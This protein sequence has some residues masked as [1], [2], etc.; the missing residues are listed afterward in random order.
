MLFG[1]DANLNNDFLGYMG[2]LL[3]YT[4]TLV[5]SQLTNT[6]SYLFNKWNTIPASPSPSPTPSFSV[7]P[8]V[9]ITPSPTPVV[10]DSI[11]AALSPSYTASYDAA[12]VGSFVLVDS[13]SYLSVSS[14]V[15]ATTYGMNESTMNGPN[16]TGTSWGAPFAFNFYQDGQIP[17]GNYIVAFSTVYNNTGNQSTAVYYG[18]GSTASGSSGTLIGNVMT[19]NVASAP[20][21]GSRQYFVRKAPTDALPANSWTYMWNN[22]GL[23]IKGPI[24]NPVQYKN[25]GSTA[26]NP[27]LAGGSYSNWTT[28]G[29]PAHQFLATTVKSW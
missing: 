12:S 27:T 24:V 25:V 6:E 22:L 28:A 3:V 19:F 26:P 16:G 4:K 9:S 8:T 14:S 5:G 20:I 23:K 11:R 10:T 15:S 1:T 21:S 29:A 7:T 18:T 17:S 13:S 2:E